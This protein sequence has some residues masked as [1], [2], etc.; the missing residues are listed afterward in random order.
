ME[1]IVQLGC[2]GH[3]GRVLGEN[4][5]LFPYKQ[6]YLIRHLVY[7]CSK[8]LIMVLSSGLE[9]KPVRASREV[10]RSILCPFRNNRS[11]HQT[12]ANQ[13]L[14]LLRVIT[15]SIDVIWELE[16][17]RSKYRPKSPLLDKMLVVLFQQR[18]SQLQIYPAGLEDV[19][20]K[21]ISFLRYL[22][23]IIVVPRERIQ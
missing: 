11:S 5:E 13:E 6:G 23:F 7:H 22:V 15:V 20:T 12:S 14:G 2:F 21:G 16:E 4:Y 10:N 3:I 8:T 17:Q 9:P 18:I 1:H 19:W